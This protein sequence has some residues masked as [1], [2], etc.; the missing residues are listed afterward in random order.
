MTAILL[1]F[2]LVT[3]AP[4]PANLAVSVLA[5]GQGP[6][7][8]IRMALGL[9]LGL[10]A[11]GIAAALGLGAMLAA[12]EVAMTG[13]RLGGGAILLWL[14]WSGLRGAGRTAAAPAAIRAPFRTGLL[15]NLSNPKAVLA[16]LAALAVGLDASAGAGPLVMAT[17]ACALIGLSNYLLWALLMSRDLPRRAYIRARRGIETGVALI[18]GAAGAELIRQGVTR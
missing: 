14:A 3:Y 12:S 13:L 18:F 17:A 7:P 11:W 4:G 15:L 8:A 1:A 9:A 16:W 5:M 2:A 6:R 10:A